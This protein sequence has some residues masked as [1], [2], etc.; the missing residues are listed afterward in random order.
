LVVAV[1]API[2]R[3]RLHVW[4][5]RQQVATSGFVKQCSTR[6]HQCRVVQRIRTL[7]VARQLPLETRDEARGRE[8]F[9]LDVSPGDRQRRRRLARGGPGFLPPF[10]ARPPPLK[11]LSCLLALSPGSERLVHSPFKSKYPSVEGLETLTCQQRVE[12]LGRN[13]FH[14]GKIE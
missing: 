14:P 13:V 1:V 9:P 6:P 8:A 2:P 12:V 7:D 11:G 10:R 5:L 3:R 4:F